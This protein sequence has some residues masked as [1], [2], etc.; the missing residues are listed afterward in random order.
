MASA[1]LHTELNP[2]T[3]ETSSEVIGNP[4]AVENRKRNALPCL[5]AQPIAKL[6]VTLLFP[7]CYQPYLSQ[8]HSICGLSILKGGL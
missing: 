2:G 8:R 5:P 4:I 1:D 6:E 3:H 7:S